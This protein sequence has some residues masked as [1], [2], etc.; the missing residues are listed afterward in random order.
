MSRLVSRIDE[1]DGRWVRLVLDGPRG[2]VLSLAVVSAL[3]AALA[4]ITPSGSV[5]WVTVEGAGGEFSF[6]ADVRE[7][8]PEPMRAVLPAT[9]ALIRELVACPAPTTA[10]V[11]GRCLG[12]GFE[13]AL[14]CDGIIATPDAQ[15]GLPEIALAAF[16]PVASLLLPR[17]VGS[18]RA[19][20]A[21]LTGEAQ[22]AEEW[23]PTGLLMVA[24]EEDLVAH[25]GRWF[26]QHL[27]GRSAVGLR[28]AVRAARL[29]TQT[30]LDHL[31]GELERQYLDELLAS[32]DSVEG[33]R[34]FIEK[35]APRW[36]HR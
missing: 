27:A 5:Q 6:G 36:E 12:G 25:A 10:L 20:R 18:A 15:L 34:A 14:A 23:Q 29:A 9:H 4:A 30:E 16:A 26:D 31:L 28:H 22:S 24:A 21:L 19:T 17:R 33:A 35:R 8:L 32:S 13:L 1:R 11:Q 7:H 2:N 3:R